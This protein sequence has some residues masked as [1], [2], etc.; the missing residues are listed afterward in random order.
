MSRNHVEANK[1]GPNINTCS[2][3]PLTNCLRVAIIPEK[4]VW[5]QLC[6]SKIRISWTCIA[7][8]CRKDI[9]LFNITI[10]YSTNYS[11]ID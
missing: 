4:E 10:N 3:T 6:Q 2:S 9:I 5:H 1:Q 8:N 11:I 7:G